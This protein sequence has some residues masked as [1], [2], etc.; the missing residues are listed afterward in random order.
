MYL[1]SDSGGRGGIT[2]ARPIQE[3]FEGLVQYLLSSNPN[4]DN[5]PFPVKIS[6]ENRWRWHPYDTRVKHHIFRNR[7]Q[8]LEG[9]RPREKHVVNAYDWPERIEEVKMRNELAKKD[10][11]EPFDQ[12][13]LTAAL[14]T[15]R[16]IT[17]TSLLWEYHKKEIMELEPGRKRQ[18]RP[19]YFFDPEG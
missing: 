1:H 10:V 8:I 5:C 13:F 18:G 4:H 14:E 9:P 2:I 17:P 16:Q 19:P 12:A 7:Y 11:G 15:N 3:Q 6:P